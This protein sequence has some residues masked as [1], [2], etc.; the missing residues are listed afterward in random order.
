MNDTVF[1]ELFVCLDCNYQ[2]YGLTQCRSHEE[3]RGHWMIVE[4]AE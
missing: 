3:S 1:D 2:T 4:D